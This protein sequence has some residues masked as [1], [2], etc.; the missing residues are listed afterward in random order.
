MCAERTVELAE[1]FLLSVQ[2]QRVFCCTPVHFPRYLSTQSDL[3]IFL[4]ARSS[5]SIRITGHP[6]SSDRLPY[7]VL[8]DHAKLLNLKPH[9]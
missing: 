3:S 4:G 2:F 1:A 6:Y 5:P 8:P 9:S 7:W